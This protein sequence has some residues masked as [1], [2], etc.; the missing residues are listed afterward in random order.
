M[1]KKI[2]TCHI[3]KENLGS[4]HGGEHEEVISKHIIFAHMNRARDIIDCGMEIERLQQRF[5]NLSGMYTRFGLH[6]FVNQNAMRAVGF[7]EKEIENYLE[8]EEWE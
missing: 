7:S 6:M 4:F 8:K 5:K 3:C 1:T 2:V